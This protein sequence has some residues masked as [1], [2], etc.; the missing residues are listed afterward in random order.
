MQDYK[1]TIGPL[2]LHYWGEPNH[3]LSTPGKE[4][5]FGSHGSKSVDLVKAT[6][7]DHEADQGGGVSDLVRFMEPNASVVDRLAQFGLPKA[8]KNERR[9]ESWD[10]VDQDGELRYQVLR[11]T[12]NGQK[13]YRQRRYE[14]GRPVWGMTGVTALPYRL[15]QIL[16]ST[17]PIF[18]CEGEKC[19]DAVAALGLLATT[20]HGGA[21]KWWPS[22]NEWF[23]GRQVII[24]PDNDAPGAKHARIVADS[25]TGTARSIRVLELPGLPTKG[26]IC[27][28]LILGGDKDQLT[29]LAKSAPIY[30]AASAAP[31]DDHC[32]ENESPIQLAEG[33]SHTTPTT[34]TT[35]TSHTSHAPEL[36]P[37]HATP[38]SWLEPASIP[39]RRFIYGTHYIR[40]FVSLDVA[41]GGVGKSTLVIAEA[42]AI[43]SGEPILGQRV[44]ERG[45]VWYF[46]GEDPM[47]EINR[48]VVA[49]VKHYRLTPES[50]AGNLFL[51][52]G[53][54]QPIVIAHQ[55]R[56]GA[57]I[58]EPVIGAVVEAIERNKIDVMILDPFVSTHQVSEND[59]NAIERVAKTWAHIAD[60]TGCAINLVHHSRKTGGNEVSVEDGRGASALVSAA[61]SAR[62]FNQMTDAEAAKAGVDN[63]R[64]YFRVDNG[65][66]NLAP[67][68]D[69]ASW[70]HLVSVPLG[71]GA[72]GTDGDMVGVVTQWEWPDH[73]AEI[74]VDQLRAA[75]REVA[76]GGQWR[77][78]HQSK[79]WVGIPIA[80]AL[81]ID[82]NL[83]SGKAKVTSLLKTWMATGMFVEVQGHDSKR[84]A[85]TFVEV[86]Q[87]AND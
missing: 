1:N 80:R 40:Q 7:F 83:K 28:W 82:L 30:D 61:R 48:R 63:R 77:A 31:I 85:R 70:F 38:F 60:I 24:L 84:M 32:S 17:A 34:P 68:S 72:G 86:G 6:W 14:N 18:I 46:N 76:S 20:N 65:K 51:D 33:T 26:D 36:R 12:Q 53:R 22:L 66:A 64:S 87:W 13:T 56:D 62:A 74:S 29:A 49:S 73:I 41:P 5:R 8:E 25:L 23:R 11:Y 3:S 58:Q 9:E 35:P 16:N 50:L 2:A 78:N 15:P 39:M 10:Y 55:T 43:A 47:D 45:R 4:L 44:H 69:A 57:L 75:Q 71:N 37:I 19:A 42:L 27:D 52:S 59:N 81:K 67:P 54:S 21:G 79:E